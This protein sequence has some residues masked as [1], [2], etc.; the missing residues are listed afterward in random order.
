MKENINQIAQELKQSRIKREEE[1]RQKE[2][3]RLSHAG[4]ITVFDAEEN[5]YVEITA[6]KQ[7]TAA[8]VHQQIVLSSFATAL[9][10]K[11]MFDEKLYLAFGCSTREEYAET[12]LP[13]G[14]RQA[15]KYYR[16]ASRF[17]PLLQLKGNS[18]ST[19]ER[20]STSPEKWNSSST[21]E[22]K[23]TSPEKWNSSSTNTEN[24]EKIKGLPIN[25]LDTLIR[26]LDDEEI[27]EL[28]NKGKIE[29]E[30]ISLTIDTIKELSQREAQKEI[31]KFKRKF[32]DKINQQEQE[33]K[34]LKAENKILLK[35]K[36]ILNEKFESLEKEYIVHGPK[37]QL[38]EEKNKT[39]DSAFKQLIDFN[40]TFVRANIKESDPDALK[41]KVIDLFDQIEE[42][43]LRFMMSYDFILGEREQYKSD[44]DP[45]WLKL[46]DVKKL[47]GNKK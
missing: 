25:T 19:E 17:E 9:S 39:L 34:L 14:Y 38:I 20:K 23:S 28:I 24:L 29:N 12:M 46:V 32:S 13:F 43:K 18:S 6:E 11:K 35:E 10:I 4:S 26:E 2:I 3:Q 5:K 30:D 45:E 27:D 47:G 8:F 1:S 22:R 33:I 44:I 42:V 41:S 31:A 36:S 40:L 37:A 7:K 16:V 15:N 21:E